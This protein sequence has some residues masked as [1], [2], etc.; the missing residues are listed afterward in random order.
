MPLYG[1]IV[2]L[3]NNTSTP[4]IVG[5]VTLFT[6]GPRPISGTPDA[7]VFPTF[8]KHPFIINLD[9][10]LKDSKHSASLTLKRDP[11]SAQE[12][13]DDVYKWVL[14]NSWVS[15]QDVPEILRSPGEFVVKFSY[16]SDTQ[17]FC[18]CAPI[19]DNLTPDQAYLLGV[20]ANG[21]WDADD[22]TVKN[23]QTA[24]KNVTSCN[25]PTI[26]NINDVPDDQNLCSYA[27][28]S[29]SGTCEPTPLCARRTSCTKCDGKKDK[30]DCE[31]EIGYCI[32]RDSGIIS[33]S[34]PFYYDSSAKLIWGKAATDESRTYY[35]PCCA[36]TNDDW[37]CS[38]V[39]DSK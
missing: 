19:T 28:K 27:Q 1:L 38:Q 7:Y 16:K 4:K 23:I 32:W 33:K 21:G 10:S 17:E 8:L 25:Q 12:D 29:G 37:L 36:S 24:C 31:K 6:T 14:A 11:T 13:H 34:A 2:T 39:E 26:W 30:T 15:T 3:P 35:Y 5:G 20:K 18:K 9:I 22:T